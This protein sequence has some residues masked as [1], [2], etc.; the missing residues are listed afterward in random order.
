MKGLYDEFAKRKDCAIYMP[1][2][3]HKGRTLDK[4]YF[5]NVVNSLYPEEMDLILKH[6]NEQRNSISGENR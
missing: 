3:V 4:E 2:K 5:F 6:A 1:P